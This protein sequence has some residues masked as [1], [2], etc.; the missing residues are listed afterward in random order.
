MIEVSTE[1]HITKS[2]LNALPDYKCH[3]TCK[4][5]WWRDDVPAVQFGM[6]LHC[7]KCNGNLASA[8]ENL[9]Y[10]VISFI[11]E[12]R[13]YPESDILIKHSSNLH[14]EFIPLI[15]KHGWK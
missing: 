10:K 11:P 15:E 4:K 13:I 9:D 5:V 8:K 14:D 1:Y 6:I 12:S 7:P 2:D 3:G